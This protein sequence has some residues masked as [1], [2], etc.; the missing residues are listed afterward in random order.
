MGRDFWENGP[1]ARARFET[2]NRLLGFDLA[3]TCFSGP[4]EKLDTT[5]VS[6]PA[7]LVT[8]IAALDA[9]EEHKKA[10][11][12]CRAAAGL[13]LGEYT[14]YVHA[15][16]LKF[17]DAVVLVHKRGK[18]MQEAAEKRPSGM[19]S[20]IGI[21]PAQAEEICRSVRSRGYAAVA[22]L[23]SPLQTVVSA[24]ESVLDSIGQLAEKAGARKVVRLKVSGGFHCQLMSPAREKL[25]A[26]LR[27]VPI[28]PGRFPVVANVSAKSVRQPEEIR[29][30]LVRQVD[31]PVRWEASMRL[32]GAE[33]FDTFCEVGPGKV[34]CGLLKGIL[35]G[36]RCE[37]VA[38]QTAG[39][40]A[41]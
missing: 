20:L 32:L 28:S 5:Y 16:A 21:K 33:G 18:F 13:S 2:A 11:P 15:G 40:A 39:G 30:A 10:R 17:E 27:G 31:S 8:S 22:N 37:P 6:Q 25:E 35:K 9:A 7:I 38:A 14:A 34:L 36:V 26:E 24:E 1:R 4:Q 41:P 23:N 29:D 19:L 12:E 3:E